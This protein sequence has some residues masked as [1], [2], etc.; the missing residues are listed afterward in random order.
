MAAIAPTAAFWLGLGCCAVLSV[1]RLRKPAACL[2]GAVVLAFAVCSNG[3]FADWLLATLERDYYRFDPLTMEPVD[4]LIVLG[5]GLG[6]RPNGNPQLTRRGDRVMLAAR[7]Y[8][9]GKAKRLLTSGD[10]IPEL[11]MDAST[12]NATARL[13]QDLGIPAPHIVI[14]RGASTGEELLNVKRYMTESGARRIG[15][16]TSAWHMR[17]AL[18]H[19]EKNGL[20]VV[21]VPA[22]FWSSEEP[23]PM[24][25]ALVPSADALGGTHRAMLEYLALAVRR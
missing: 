5:G 18:R 15:L 1:A 6:V 11:G 19:A 22:D 12:A 23:G 25:F 7:L 4:A 21:P 24:L 13:W 2:F 8:H 3:I 9:L 20:S 14:G 16:L 17:R 10:P